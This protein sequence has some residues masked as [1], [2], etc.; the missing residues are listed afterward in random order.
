MS[1]NVIL[2]A[3]GLAS[4]VFGKARVIVRSGRKKMP[5][6][7]NALITNKKGREYPCPNQ[8]YLYQCSGFYLD[9]FPKGHVVF[10]VLGG[11]QWLRIKPGR[12]VIALAICFYSVVAG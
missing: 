10:D 11:I 4:P 5:V 8:S 12:I 6:S 3:A 2:P 1:A 7:C 9:T